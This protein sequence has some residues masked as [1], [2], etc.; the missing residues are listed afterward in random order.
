MSDYGAPDAGQPGP[1]RPASRE[2]R[3]RRSWL[4]PPHQATLGAERS[5]N[6]TAGTPQRPAGG[7][8]LRLMRVGQAASAWPAT[9]TGTV[10]ARRARTARAP[11]RASSMARE[12]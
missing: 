1:A 5:G 2:V 8:A 4:G 12:K 11:V 10:Q 7:G 6:V 3:G 9:G